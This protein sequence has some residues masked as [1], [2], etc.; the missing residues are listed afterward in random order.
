MR[1]RLILVVAAEEL[2]SKLKYLRKLFSGSDLNSHDT[3]EP[4]LVIAFPMVSGELAGKRLSLVGRSLGYT[5]LYFDSNDNISI[6]SDINDEIS[7]HLVSK[8]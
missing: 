5:L 8:L 7:L 4:N 6:S 3:R 2:Y 1:T